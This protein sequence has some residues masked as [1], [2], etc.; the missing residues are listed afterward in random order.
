M[1][2]HERIAELTD[3]VAPEDGRTLEIADLATGYGRTARAILATAKGPVRIHAVDTGP[4]IDDDLLHDPRVRPVLADL[5][6]PLPFAG[7]RLDRVTSVNVAEH[8]AD[9]R[10][11]VA[12]CYRVLRPGGLLVLMHSDWDTTLVSSDDDALTRRLV[13][14]FVATVPKWVEHADGFMGRKLLGLATAAPFEVVAVDT[15]AD[16]HRRFDED[17]VAW[18]VARGVLAAAAGDPELAP[19]AARWIQ[20]LRRY[21]EENRFL[22]SVI[23]VAVVLRRPE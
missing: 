14:T 17:S 13:D 9:P 2:R 22:F 16:C 3:P 15:W 5:D 10:A 23:D 4:I 21:A 8:L 12:E 7:R 18:K 11:H 6:E 19:L 20:T 1:G